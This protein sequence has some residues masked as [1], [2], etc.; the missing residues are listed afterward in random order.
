LTIRPSRPGRN[1]LLLYL[2]PT[3]REEAAGAVPIDLTVNGRP[4]AVQPCGPS[5]ARAAADLQGH[6]RVEARIRTRNGGTVAFDLPALPA[7]DGR[8]IFER[9]Q[10]RMHAL[11]TFRVDEVLGPAEPPVRT[12]YAYQAPDR[13]QF[14]MDSGFQTVWVGS[15]RYD[16]P[17]PDAPW[18]AQHFVNLIMQVPRFVWDLPG[19]PRYLAL[20]LAGSEQVD[21]VETQILA[22]FVHSG[23]TP[24]WFR[25]WVDGEG[26]V[27]R[28]LMHAEGHFMQ[29]RY[30]DFDAPFT[31]EPPPV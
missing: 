26:L 12:V 5:C 1:D 25:L 16:R 14:Q 11:K 23:R 17:S 19:A 21:G 6:E 2:L 9:M 29:H 3:D 18:Q 30:Y 15:T 31:I 8:A 13:M 10:A 24:I 22:F 27:H 7:P 4:L 20:R 28:A